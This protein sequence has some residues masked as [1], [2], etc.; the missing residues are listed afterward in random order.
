MSNDTKPELVSCTFD[1]SK[2]PKPIEPEAHVVACTIHKELEPQVVACTFDQN[3]GRSESEKKEEECKKDEDTNLPP[4]CPKCGN[5]SN[6]VK[7]VFGLPTP[8]LAKEAEDGKIALGGCCPP[9]PGEKCRTYKCKTCK[10]D[11]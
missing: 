9:M 5:N 2:M 6:V 8:E 7:I 1:S 10:H 11:F 3:A 4:S